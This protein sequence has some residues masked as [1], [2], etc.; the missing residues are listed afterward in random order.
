MSQPSSEERRKFVLVFTGPATSQDGAAA[1]IR[2][3]VS[4]IERWFKW[5]NEMQFDLP[6]NA[7]V[8][9]KEA[10][11]REKAEKAKS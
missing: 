2:G 6:L 3:L 10:D 4:Y 7:K 5:K 1:P 9:I 8:E 11:E